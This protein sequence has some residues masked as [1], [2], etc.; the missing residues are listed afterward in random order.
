M[1][2]DVVWLVEDADE[3][4]L[5]RYQNRDSATCLGLELREFDELC[6]GV[7]T[8]FQALIREHAILERV[9][10][11]REQKFIDHQYS[12]LGSDHVSGVNRL[13][14][15]LIERNGFRFCHFLLLLDES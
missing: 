5:R 9:N 10:S 14:H 15:P 3:N 1:L 4:P 8:I 7:V 11:M 6:Y 12:F 13:V 2:I